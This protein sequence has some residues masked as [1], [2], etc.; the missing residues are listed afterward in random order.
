MINNI[1][2]AWSITER[3]TREEQDKW[4]DGKSDDQNLT[5]QQFFN[6]LNISIESV[7]NRPP[8][9]FDLLDSLSDEKRELF[10]IKKKINKNLSL[11]QFIKNENL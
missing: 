7:L 8:I 10:H 4:I 3:M 9:N 2:S 11:E 6:N 5:L 1:G